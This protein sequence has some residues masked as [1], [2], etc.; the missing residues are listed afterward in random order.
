[1]TVAKHLGGSSSGHAGVPGKTRQKSKPMLPK[2][3]KPK[4]L[5]NTISTGGGGGGFETRVQAI[6][7]LAMLMGD[8][9]PEHFDGT[10]VKL[11]FQARKHGFQTDDLV[12]ITENEQGRQRK[13][14]LQVK[15]TVRPS[16]ADKQFYEAMSA[17]WLDYRNLDLFEVSADALVV[18][19]DSECYDKM[20]GARRIVQW[21]RGSTSIDEFDNNF[22]PGA[23]N[24]ADRNAR[25][26]VHAI[27][28]DVVSGPVAPVQLFEFLKHVQFIDHKLTFEEG[29][30]YT[31]RLNTI[32]RAVGKEFEPQL[33][34][35]QLVNS[36]QKQNTVG[37]AVLLSD[38]EALLGSRLAA[39]FARYREVLST[40]GKALWT[41]A[42]HQGQS[43]AAYE[44]GHYSAASNL[45]LSSGTTSK[46]T[47][48]GAATD[49]PSARDTSLNKVISGQLDAINQQVKSYR[50]VDAQ[51]AIA[52]L[53]RDLGPFDSHQRARWYFLRGTCS[54]HSG[55]IEE[56]ASDFVKSAEL[57]QDEDLFAATK[58]R[59]LMLQEK[60]AEA[61]AA[62]RN[63]RERFPESITVWLA[64]ANVRLAIGEVVELA[65]APARH[66][67]DSSVC[68][69]V[70]VGFQLRGDLGR[71][72][73][74][75]TEA[76]RHA[77]CSFYARQTALSFSLQKA[78]GN[79][80][81]FVFGLVATDD[82]VALRQVVEAFA[83]RSERLWAVQAREA[84]ADVVTNL[85]YAN[86]LLGEPQQAHEILGEARSRDIASPRFYRPEFEAILQLKGVGAAT[87]W[88]ADNLA[89]MPEE[90]I[91]GFAQAAANTGDVEAV[92]AA[93][94][95]S[96]RLIARRSNLDVTLKAFRWLALENSPQDLRPALRAE[97]SSLMLDTSD[98]LPLLCVGARFLVNE[99]CALEAEPLLQRA[100][101]LVAADPTSE[102]LYLVAELLFTANRF[103]EAALLYDEFLPVGQ[104]SELHNHLL[105]C[106]VRG[107]AWPQAKRMLQR[108]PDGWVDDEGARALAIELGQKAGDWQLLSTLAEAQF[109]RAPGKASSWLFKLMVAARADSLAH[110]IEFLGEAPIS[111]DGTPRQLA[112]IAS[113]EMRLGVPLRG[114][115]R[116]Y[117]MRRLNLEALEAAS[118]YAI[119]HYAFGDALP[120][121]VNV[122]EVVEAGTSVTLVD[123]SG[124]FVTI[125]FD[126]VDIR[127][128]PE[129]SEFKNSNSPEA[130]LLFGKR[131]GEVLTV[132]LSFGASKC[133]RVTQI[134]TAYRRLLAESDEMLSKSVT[135]TPFA[136]K[137]RVET[138]AD[139]SKDFTEFKRMLQ[140]RSGHVAYAIETYRDVPITLGGFAKILGSDVIDVVRTW[141]VKGPALF[142]GGGEPSELADALELLDDKNAT[143]VIDA[144]TI[145]E[146]SICG[147]LGV[148][149]VLPKVFVASKTRDMISQKLEEARNDWS[150]GQAYEIDGQLGYAEYSDADH[151][152]NVVQ[153][154]AM[155]DA[156]KQY[157]SVEPAYGPEQRTGSLERAGSVIS[158]EEYAA[159][160]LSA[161]KGARLVCLDGRLR[162]VAKECGIPGV[163]PQALFKFSVSIEAVSIQQ[164]SQAVA[165]L[166][167]SNR[168]FVS[169]TAFDLA[170]LCYLG[171]AWFQL[172]LKKFKQYLASDLTDYQSATKVVL[173]FFRLLANLGHCQLPAYGE[174]LRHL[175]EALLRH[176]ASTPLLRELIV[177][178][179]HEQFG[180]VPD[181]SSL[182]PAVAQ[183]RTE[184]SRRQIQYLIGQI[185][186]AEEA[187][188]HL[189]HGTPIHVEV[190]FCS[191]PPWLVYR[192]TTDRQDRGIQHHERPG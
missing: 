13:A 172:G 113:A 138:R 36:C 43:T 144:A 45:A 150:V 187:S 146:L 139:G 105:C 97:I 120:H 184:V 60:M 152:R 156:V 67:N 37:G 71:A 62:A 6:R 5:S 7:L 104:H 140:Q 88:G 122:P 154:Q 174:L 24:D 12:C 98:S 101:V 74:L 75:A 132:P 180:G 33:V 151:A 2:P 145:T 148:L 164:Y 100:Q 51:A 20:T 135:P 170:H 165:R 107:G 118:V 167:L 35:S 160:L 50:Y 61:A 130:S 29:S 90:A 128:L 159:L 17:A 178:F 77:E 59:G 147:L 10:V 112:G 116:L 183:Y 63:A 129:T 121:L 153:L 169:V 73:K 80:V 133:V 93:I 96:S 131:V 95:A 115:Q 8:S 28:A 173:D 157:C 85:A 41:D 34:W 182:Y 65:D 176:K 126:P 32:R 119:T 26:A 40:I 82:K 18:V 191:N 117:R 92:T 3:F 103:P 162:S 81:S 106:Y 69:M 11:L 123:D 55:E 49:V 25:A 53:G 39:A 110:Q 27:V 14:L 86:L 19:H 87:A 149:G 31:D 189:E 46:Q 89:N 21:A 66:R 127:D 188:K 1:M 72:V 78:F 171:G 76:L 42:N 179:L 168:S 79:G 58:V 68:Q 22:Q 84:V 64:W 124:L 56:A 48:I 57:C 125:T 177:T 192:D 16:E 47:A 181:L 38:A 99:Q 15:R 70:A 134:S 158:G 23:C 155:A 108:L 109:L 54:W 161:E 111:L 143:Y 137:V 9:V 190:L 94:E 91:I 166:L 141:G 52:V 175:A 136:V 142:V 163:W 186:E 102:N 185:D 114:T 83:P 44:S 30:E 4:Q